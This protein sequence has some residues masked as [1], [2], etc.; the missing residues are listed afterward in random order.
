MFSHA[1]PPIASTAPGNYQPAL[2]CFA[3]FSIL[4]THTLS[5]VC[6]FLLLLLNFSHSAYLFGS[7]ILCMCVGWRV[8]GIEL[9]ALGLVGRLSTT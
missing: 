7:K 3:I 8:L 4:W 6:L 5:I 1:F 9:T 2:D